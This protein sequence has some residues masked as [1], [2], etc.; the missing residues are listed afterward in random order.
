M[1]PF[2]VEPTR[3]KIRYLLIVSPSGSF[4]HTRFVLRQRQ[5]SF[6]LLPLLTR[7]G[8]EGSAVRGFAFYAP[9][10]LV[11]HFLTALQEISSCKKHLSDFSFALPCVFLGMAPF[12]VWPIRSRYNDLLVGPP[13]CSFH[14]TRVYLTAKT[15]QLRQPGLVKR[16]RQDNSESTSPSPSLVRRGVLP[17]LLPLLTRG[18]WEGL[19]GER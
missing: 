18:G 19:A 6:S 13:L 11:G 5:G 9:D 17:S 7:G 3:S 12:A 4:H 14:H 15:K 16:Q 8:R 1:A 10:A 2:A